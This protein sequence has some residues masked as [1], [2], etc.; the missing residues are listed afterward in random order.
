VLL[1]ADDRRH[2]EEKHVFHNEYVVPLYRGCLAEINLAVDYDE[3]R[4]SR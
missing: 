4:I 2:I 1:A 3:R